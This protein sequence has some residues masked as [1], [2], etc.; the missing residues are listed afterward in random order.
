MNYIA[1]AVVKTVSKIT[2]NWPDYVWHLNDMLNLEGMLNSL[3][4]STFLGTVTILSKF[5]IIFTF[6]FGSIILEMEHY[7]K[8]RY[9][10]DLDTLIFACKHQMTRIAA[11]L[12][13]VSTCLDET[14][15]ECDVLASEIQKIVTTSQNCDSKSK[16]EQ[17]KTELTKK[18]VQMMSVLRYYKTHKTRAQ[19][20]M[21]EAM[22]R[23]GVLMARKVHFQHC[24]RE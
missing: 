15:S 16:E 18:L 11:E 22:G 21:E 5:Y 17:L 13:V 7:R 20:E 10:T 2:T 12:N 8:I 3:F 4:N 9:E 14:K 23:F 24:H 19:T 6:H 1:L